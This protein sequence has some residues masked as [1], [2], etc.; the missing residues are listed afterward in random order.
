[1]THL[2]KCILVAV[3]A[4]YF[5]LLKDEGGVLEGLVTAATDKVLGVPHLAHG[6]RKRAPRGVVWVVGVWS[7]GGGEGQR[8]IYY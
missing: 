2:S 3:L 5:L 8:E 4:E 1:M 7:R 6:A